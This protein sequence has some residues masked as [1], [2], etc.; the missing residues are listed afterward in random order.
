M[1]DVK[2]LRVN[3]LMQ[4]MGI[5]RDRAYAIMKSKGF[6]AMKIGVTYFVTETNFYRWLDDYAGKEFKFD[7]EKGA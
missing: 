4:R 3:D 2:I 7:N 6:P 1:D 5:G